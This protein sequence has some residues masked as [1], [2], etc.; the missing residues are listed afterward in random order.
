MPALRSVPRSVPARPIE[1]GCVV[2]FARPPTRPATFSMRDRIELARWSDQAV[3]LGISRVRLEVPEPD[4]DPA[5][6]GFLLIYRDRGDWA[7]WALAPRADMSF[8][9]WSMRDMTTLGCFPCLTEAL[10]RVAAAA[11]GLRA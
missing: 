4:D 11:S 2:A 3:Q 10:Q 8:E 9:L 1:R 5:S 6:G 7:T